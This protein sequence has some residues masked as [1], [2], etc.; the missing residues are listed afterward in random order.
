MD[1][2]EEKARRNI[3][4]TSND[5]EDNLKRQ[6]RVPT[7]YAED[8]VSDIIYANQTEIDSANRNIL[9]NVNEFIKDMQNELAGVSEVSDILSQVQMSLVVLVVLSV[10]SSSL[11]AFGC[12]LNLILQCPISIVWHM[13]DLH[14]RH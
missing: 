12:E 6:P 1:N 3:G 13:Q 9:D 4:N 14:N 2:A 10:C 8:L 7:C 11:N 5:D